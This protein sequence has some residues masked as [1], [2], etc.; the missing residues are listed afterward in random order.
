[1]RRGNCDRDTGRNR[2]R[3]RRRRKRKAKPVAQMAAKARAI[4]LVVSRIARLP[5]AHIGAEHLRIAGERRQFGER[6][7]SRR[8]S[9]RSQKRRV[10]RR[11]EKLKDERRGADEKREATARAS[12]RP[13]LALLI[14]PLAPSCSARQSTPPADHTQRSGDDQSPRCECSPQPIAVFTVSMSCLSVNGFG[15]KVKRSP[16]GRFLANAS[17]A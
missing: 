6:G 5:V 9:R 16:S 7:R 2:W 17:S 12:K 15:R 11:Q 10:Q 3:E 13:P 4:G 1:M 14:S 8:K